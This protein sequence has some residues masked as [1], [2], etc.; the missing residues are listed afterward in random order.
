MRLSSPRLQAPAPRNKG[1]H[2]MTGIPNRV[3]RPTDQRG[4]WGSVEQFPNERL[5]NGVNNGAQI[6][7]PTNKGRAQVLYVAAISP[8]LSGPC[9]LLN[10]ANEVEQALSCNI[11][12]DDVLAGSHPDLRV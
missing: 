5:I 10:E 7:I 9:I 3:T 1:K 12:D 6:W 8:R 2:R 11:V 4:K